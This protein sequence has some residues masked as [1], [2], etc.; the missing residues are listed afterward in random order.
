MGT[1]ALNTI[2]EDVTVVT[3]PGALQV[4]GQLH[5]RATASIVYIGE[6]VKCQNKSEDLDFFFLRFLI[7]T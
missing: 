7:L 2:L 3:G 6:I 5:D 1:P 4:G